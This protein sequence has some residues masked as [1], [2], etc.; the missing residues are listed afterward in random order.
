VE[1][2]RQYPGLK[3]EHVAAALGY[4]A[5]LARERVVPIPA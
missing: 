5:E 1:I 2:L 3:A 4:A